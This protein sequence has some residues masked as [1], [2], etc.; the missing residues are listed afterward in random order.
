MASK[1]KQSLAIIIPMYNE[2]TVA[3]SCIDAVIKVIKKQKQKIKLIVI[4]DGSKDTTGEILQKK[5]QRYGHVLIVLTH[6]KNKGY[7]AATQTG[8]KKAAQ[9]GFTWILHMDSD[10]TNDPKYIPKF[11]TSMSDDVDCVKASRYNKGA[12][13]ENVPAFRRSVSV[14]GNFLAA[15][16][17]NIGIKDCTNGFRMVRT[18]MLKGVTFKENNFSIILE[19]LYYLKK[20]HAKFKEIPYTLTART[21]S[22]S[23]FVYKP[24][25]FYDYLKYVLKALFLFQV[26][27]LTSQLFVAR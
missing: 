24:K 4:N 1:S 21:N 18:A 26:I 14:I 15:L 12:K 2:E 6:K 9:L 11:I 16:L 25:T 22:I 13:T 3:A 23:H 27:L 20:R 5:A 17:F 19:E 10:L 7:G 8:I